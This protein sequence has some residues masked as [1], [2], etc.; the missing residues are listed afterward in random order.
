[1]TNSP[2]HADA[3]RADSWRRLLGSGR[4]TL[5]AGVTTATLL[6]AP[7]AAAFFQLPDGP[8][9][10]SGTAQVVAQG[11]VRIGRGDLQWQIAER[12]APPPANS[13]AV[14]SNLGFLTVTSGSM[15]VDDADSGVQHRLAA[16][17]ALL[18]VEGTEQS[19][20]ALGSDSSSYFEISLVEQ[21]NESPADDALLFASDP[22]DGLGARHDIDLL[23]DTLPPG[24]ALSIPAGSLPTLVIVEA[25][26]AQVATEA[27]DVVSLGPGEAVSLAGTLVVTATERGAE[28]SSVYTGPAV[29]QLAQAAATPRAGRAVETTT[30]SSG[31]DASP[32]A[33]AA[34][35]A[36]EDADDDGLTAADET[37][38]GTDAALADTDEDG[39]TDGQEVLEYG[40]MPLS[41]DT[42][43]DGVLDGDEVAQGT[44]PLGDG[45]IAVDPVVEEP[46]SAEV[47]AGEEPAP[48]AEEPVAEPAAAAGDTDG[49]GL[50]DAIEAELG[51]DP[52]DVDTDD[53]GATDGD[54]YYVHQTGTRNPDS[55]GDGVPDG[56]EAANGTDP[57]DPGS[58]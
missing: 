13:V 36:E 49:D 42:D 58:F 24:A 27:G 15:L 48:V 18:T 34:S 54:E 45:A 1:V 32:V 23:S 12:V 20:V 50:E 5:I 21:A 22:F 9:P 41:A 33:T 25:G 43:G 2:D 19:R 39:L 7:A 51:T 57:N 31:A 11:V 30:G 10:A 47:P 52:F 55:D 4:L 37:A 8:S 56:T 28:V 40:T 53:D 35:A 17:E 3:G 26:G 46:V 16:G 44:D 6:L 14:K 38:S 29:P